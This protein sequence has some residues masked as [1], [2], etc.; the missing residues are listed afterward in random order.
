[1][2]STRRGTEVVAFGG[3]DKVVQVS[4]AAVELEG[5]AISRHDIEIVSEFF[6][7]D[8]NF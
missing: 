4:I 8:Q 1:M 5:R 3:G 7:Y 2:S 6:T